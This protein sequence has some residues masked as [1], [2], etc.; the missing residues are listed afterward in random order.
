MTARTRESRQK[1]AKL[2]QNTI[3]EDLRDCLGVCDEDIKPSLMSEQGMDIK[4]SSAARARFPYAVECKNVE[5]LDLWAAIEQA[6]TNAEKEKLKPL[7]LFKRSRSDIFAVIK[8]DDFLDL[9][10]KEV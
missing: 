8:W 9:I 1:K 6:K 3:A 10:R 2:L 4:L 5:K 7:V